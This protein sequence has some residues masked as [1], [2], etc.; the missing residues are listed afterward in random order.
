MKNKLLQELSE[1]ASEGMVV[2]NQTADLT[3]LEMC[4]LSVNSSLMEKRVVLRRERN[5]CSRP[6]IHV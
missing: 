6:L 1:L 3:A 5:Q 2:K 4:V